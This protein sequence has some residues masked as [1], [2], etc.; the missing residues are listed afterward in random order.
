MQKCALFNGMGEE[1]YG[2]LIKCLNPQIRHFSKNEILLLTGDKVR[3]IGI[4]VKGSAAAYLEKADGTQTLISN[5]APMSV[6]GEVLVSAQAQKSPVTI[7]ATTDITAAF[8][9]FEKIYSICATNCNAHIIFLQNMLKIIGDKYFQLFDRIAILREK[10]LRL[11]IISYLE[12]LSTNAPNETLTLPFSKTMLANYLLV[13]RS[14]LSKEL[15]KMQQ[16][17]II[18]IKGR[19]IKKH[20]EKI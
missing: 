17:G 8:I 4:L 5:L 13:N 12:N 15:K 18:S 20:L 6:F 16:E 10:T 9:Q 3:H 14:A 2:R 7:Y 11:K 1:E 19:K